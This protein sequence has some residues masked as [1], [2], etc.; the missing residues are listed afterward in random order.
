M[1]ARLAHLLRR[2]SEH[3]DGA[4]LRVYRALFGLL[5]AGALVR[6]HLTGWTAPLFFEPSFRF[7]YEAF[8][9]IPAMPKGLVPWSL[10]VGAVGALTLG[11]ARGATRRLGGLVF[12]ACFAWLK[13]YDVT[14]YLNHD[15]LAFLLGALLTILPLDGPTV[16]RW[17]WWLLRFQVGVVY[18]HAGLA[19]VNTDWLLHGQ[20]LETW[21]AA[22]RGLPVLGPLLALPFAPLVGGW[23]ACL[24]DLTIPLWLSINRTRRFALAAV[25]VFHGATYALFDIGIFPFLMTLNAS[26]FLDPSWPRRFLGKLVESPGQQ[27]P[28]SPALAGALVVFVAFQAFFPLRSHAISDDV[29]WDEQGMR[30]SWKVML[31]EKNGAVSYRVRVKGEAREWQVDPLDVLT[32]RQ[33]NEMSG[34]P[35]LIVQLGRH[36]GR[37]MAAKLGRPVEVFV[38]ARVSLNRRPPAPLFR[39]DVDLL[40]LEGSDLRPALLPSPRGRGP[41]DQVAVR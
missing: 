10:A 21:F 7:E 14:N 25:L 19:K 11:L 9:F 18:V 17:A 41:V 32:P 40:S 33:A 30:W 29:L 2:L 39:P 22:N 6:L 24:Y 12:L 20:P 27:R 13:L 5:L 31:R 1:R 4:S 37:D 8:A 36:L 38:D 28:L 15:Y 3:E 23:A 35:D 16:P 34:Q 26:L